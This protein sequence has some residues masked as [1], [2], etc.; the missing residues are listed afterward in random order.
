MSPTEMSGLRAL[1][2]GTE[3]RL[4]R[5]PPAPRRD[6]QPALPGASGPGRPVQPPG[7]RPPRFPPRLAPPRAAPPRAL[8]PRRSAPGTRTAVPL[9]STAELPRG[10][11]LSTTARDSPRLLPGRRSVPVPAPAPSEAGASAPAVVAAAAAAPGRCAGPADPA[12]LHR[13]PPA[14]RS[15]RPAQGSA[16]APQRRPGPRPRCACAVTSGR[17]VCFCN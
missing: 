1:A 5:R 15:A 2:G 11:P 6:R 13:P 3:P 7:M 10:L 4:C 12:R 14:S 8:S 9:D 16:H 17:S